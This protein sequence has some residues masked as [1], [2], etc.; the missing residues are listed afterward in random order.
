ML[1]RAD[2]GQFVG[3]ARDSWQSFAKSHAGNRGWD[4]LHFPLD[5][6]GGVWLWIERL[7]LGRR[8]VQEE[9]DAGFGFWG[10]CCRRSEQIADGRAE[11][12]ESTDLNEVAAGEAVAEPASGAEQ[13]D[14][15]D[16]QRTIA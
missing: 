16:T 11:R 12:A 10:L 15:R 9:Q 3:G 13:A 7:M 14:H 1:H 8:T 6:T 2:D 4:R 5:F